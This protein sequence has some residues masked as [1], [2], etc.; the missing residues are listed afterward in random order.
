MRTESKTLKVWDHL[1]YMY[2]DGRIILKW[3]LN[4]L[5]IGYGV[6]PTDSR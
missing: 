2:V 3:A 1:G 4:I 6:D 5:D